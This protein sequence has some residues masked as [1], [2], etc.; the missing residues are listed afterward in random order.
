MAYSTL[1]RSA[2]SLLGAE[3]FERLRG[4]FYVAKQGR[5]NRRSVQEHTQPG[6][7]FLAREIAYLTGRDAAWIEDT[8]AEYRACESAWTR[9]SGL[10]SP[11]K[12]SDGYIQTLDVAE[13]FAMWAL[14]KHVRPQVVVELGTQYGISAR[15]WKDALNLYAPGHRLYLCDLED[16]RLFIGD[17]EAHFLLG[18]A[19]DSLAHIF[20]HEKVD[21]LFN[22][23][24]PYSLITWSLEQGMAHGVP[25]FAFHDVGGRALR[26][27]PFHI[28]SHALPESE[29]VASG[30]SDGIGGHWERHCMADAFDLRILTQDAVENNT[31]RLQIFDS[32]FGFGVALRTDWSPGA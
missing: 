15:L 4:R 11:D 14:V 8:A 28:E 29:R 25:C 3:R 30:A 27:G 23:A 20:A 32:L 18:D 12:Y 24:H 10:R 2:R 16:R 21:I 7:V 22:D 6:R 5:A 19:R 31:W 13:G 1:T 9:L 26:G 17:G